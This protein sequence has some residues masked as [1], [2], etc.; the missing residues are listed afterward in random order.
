MRI[1][2]MFEPHPGV[3]INNN[4]TFKHYGENYLSDFSAEYAGFVLLDS[5]DTKYDRGEP[6]YQFI[7]ENVNDWTIQQIKN[8][9]EHN[10]MHGYYTHIRIEGN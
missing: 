3:N 6:L 10:P 8:Y 5:N 4:Q 2:L 7:I 9:I 1:R